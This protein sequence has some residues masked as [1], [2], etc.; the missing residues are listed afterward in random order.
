[1][2]ENGAT[3]DVPGSHKPASCQLLSRLRGS[4]HAHVV[5]C[6]I[7]WLDEEA[8]HLLR[9]QS[10]STESYWQCARTTFDPKT[11]PYS[12]LSIQVYVQIVHRFIL[13]PRAP[14]CNQFGADA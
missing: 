4:T 1:M 14:R 6:A 3:G 5:A 13:D 2:R 12:R 9:Q 10:I 11:L 8:D 7:R